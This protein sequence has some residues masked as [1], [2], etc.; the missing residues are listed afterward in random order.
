[1]P[2]H[3]GSEALNSGGDLFIFGLGPARFALYARHAILSVLTGAYYVEA[4]EKVVMKAVLYLL[5]LLVGLPSFADGVR[6]NPGIIG[7]SVYIQRV[8]EDA[9]S[10]S[11]FHG[12]TADPSLMEAQYMGG[13]NTGPCSR[14]TPHGQY[15]FCNHGV[16]RSRDGLRDGWYFDGKFAM[17]TGFS[18]S[19]NKGSHTA[20]CRRD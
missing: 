14:N 11:I 6:A 7:N 15:C 12:E 17:R 18:F 1:V 5:M 16:R 13:P 2:L 8:D 10:E 19:Y 4:N 3:V 9:V 20:V